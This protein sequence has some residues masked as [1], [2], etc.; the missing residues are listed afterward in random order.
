MNILFLF[1][2]QFKTKFLFIVKKKFPAFCR[3]EVHV[4][5]DIVIENIE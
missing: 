1:D 4:Y 5:E 2:L 3:I